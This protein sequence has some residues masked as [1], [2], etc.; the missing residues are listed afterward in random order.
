MYGKFDGVSCPSVLPVTRARL[1]VEVR[2][3]WSQNTCTYL[4]RMIGACGTVSRGGRA[5]GFRSSLELDR[6]RLSHSKVSL[7]VL[8]V[9]AVTARTSSALLTQRARVPPPLL[10]EYGADLTLH[11]YMYSVRAAAIQ[12]HPFTARERRNHASQHATCNKPDSTANKNMRGTRPT[13]A[14]HHWPDYD[15]HPPVRGWCKVTGQHKH[16][17]SVRTCMIEC[18][19]VLVRSTCASHFPSASC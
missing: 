19:Y 2:L 7:L 14:R 1:R 12:R 18:T 13:S 17:Y 6:G 10:Q 3:E 15:G 11:D 4:T 9:F 16:R 8:L 5:S